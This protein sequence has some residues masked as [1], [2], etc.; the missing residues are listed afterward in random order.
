MPAR[1][2]TAV[3]LLFAL[4]TAC[5]PEGGEKPESPRA[6]PSG[7]PS[8]DPTDSAWVQLMIP[9]DEQAMAL[10]DLAAR[11]AT[12]P[13]LRSWAARLHSAHA[14]ELASLRALRDRMGLPDTDVHKGHDMPG[15]VTAEDLVR[16][17]AARGAAFDRLLVTQIHDHLRQSAQVS[18]S[19][20]SAGSAAEARSR[21]R[22]LVTARGEQVAGLCAG[23]AADVPE[24]FACG[25]DHPV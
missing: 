17:R 3:V 8:A 1:R 21:A 19:E 23:K 15:M 7:A 13:G 4:L 9:M 16:A 25:S 14:T 11:K 12:G 20:S 18:R 10:L 22:E 6:E 24:P 5:S 2:T